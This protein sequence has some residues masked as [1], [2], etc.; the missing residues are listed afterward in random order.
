[1]SDAPE[2]A[3]Y[4]TLIAR[5]Y[6]DP[7]NPGA[8]ILDQ[9]GNVK[10]FHRWSGHSLRAGFLSEGASRNASLASLKKQ[11]RHASVTVLSGYIRSSE[12]WKDNASETV[13]RDR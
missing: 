11:S 10:F 5:D 9:A 4:H 6:A 13:F 12:L 8:P 2:D 1:M 7:V 3:P